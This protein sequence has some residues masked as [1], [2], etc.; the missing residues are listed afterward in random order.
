MDFWDIANDWVEKA[1][2][3][4]A[5][6]E[7]TVVYR[8]GFVDK[9]TFEIIGNYN[10]DL[11]DTEGLLLEDLLDCEVIKYIESFLYDVQNGRLNYVDIGLI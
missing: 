6:I 4:G 2:E 3:K 1:L 8:T 11:W 7:V 5:N 10:F 9:Y